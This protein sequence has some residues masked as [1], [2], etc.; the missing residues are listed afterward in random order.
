M[1]VYCRGETT[2]LAQPGDHVSITGVSFE[3]IFII[4]L[5]QYQA[6]ALNFSE[7]FTLSALLWKQSSDYVIPFMCMSMIEMFRIFCTRIYK[8]YPSFLLHLPVTVFIWL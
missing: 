4:Q 8:V 3:N 7:S 2:R 5:F 6:V 1:T